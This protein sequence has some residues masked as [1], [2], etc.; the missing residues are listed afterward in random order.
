[1]INESLK[2]AKCES[3]KSK[4]DNNS[5]QIRNKPFKCF[6][7]GDQCKNRKKECSAWHHILNNLNNSEDISSATLRMK[8]TDENKVTVNF[9]LD[10]G[11]A[12]IILAILGFRSLY[13][14]RI[15]KFEKNIDVISN[16]YCSSLS[17]CDASFGYLN[18]MYHSIVNEF[19]HI[20][21]ENPGKVKKFSHTIPL[22]TRSDG[23]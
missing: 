12:I 22:I 18:P 9:L 20:F 1:M 7:C 14:L 11:S 17:K 6:G 19:K 13:E 15:I 3:S 8:I 5:P 2:L 21:S 23:K 10:T 4:F 16:K